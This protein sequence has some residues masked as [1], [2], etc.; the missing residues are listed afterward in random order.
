MQNKQIGQ[1]NLSDAVAVYFPP[2]CFS[3]IIPC[4]RRPLVQNEMAKEDP[5]ETENK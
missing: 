1:G 5:R 2:S 3:I 4:E